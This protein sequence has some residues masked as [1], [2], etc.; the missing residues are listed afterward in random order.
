MRSLRGGTP[1]AACPPNT[2]PAAAAA[3]CPSPQTLTVSATTPNRNI[4]D[5]AAIIDCLEDPD[6]SIKLKTLELL[7]VMTKASNVAVVV[8]RLML[9]LRGCTDDH[10]R[11][12]I[13]TKV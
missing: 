11:R 2:Q 12:S 13:A 10:A 3:D 6:D 8:E 9:F 4:H 5:K 7:A 1:C